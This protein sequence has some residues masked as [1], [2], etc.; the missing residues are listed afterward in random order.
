M[1]PKILKLNLLAFLSHVTTYCVAL[2]KLFQISVSQS[3]HPSKESKYLICGIVGNVNCVNTS[4]GPGYCL[5][6]QMQHIYLRTL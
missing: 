5:A 2:G 3:P 6:Q 1:K 4:K